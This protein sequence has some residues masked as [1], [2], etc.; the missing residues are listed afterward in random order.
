ME[1]I[2]YT[3][4]A[5]YHYLNDFLKVMSTSTAK[6]ITLSPV[7]MK[8]S[9]ARWSPLNCKYISEKYFKIES[10]NNP[11]IGNKYQ[12]YLR[13]LYFFHVII[14]STMRPKYIAMRYID[15]INHL[16]HGLFGYGSGHKTAAP[17][18]YGSTWR[19]PKTIVARHSSS[20]ACRSACSGIITSDCLLPCLNDRLDT[21]DMALR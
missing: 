11:P 6:A 2:R 9:I 21:H 4:R 10:A 12:K 15:L 14:S 18:D 20:P 7:N 16:I 8:N 19:N 5:A 17:S 13:S 1:W 3:R